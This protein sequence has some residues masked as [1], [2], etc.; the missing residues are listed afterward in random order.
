MELPQIKGVGKILA[1]LLL[2][3][4]TAFAVQTI[5]AYF[6]NKMPQPGKG[7]DA[8]YSGKR[9]KM[10]LIEGKDSTAAVVQ[11]K[12][13]AGIVELNKKKDTLAETIKTKKG[14]N[15]VDV[16]Y[17]SDS[18]QLKTLTDSVSALQ[19]KL[20]ELPNQHNDISEG[21]NKI[22]L[23]IIL[24]ILVATMGFLGNMVHIASSFTSFIGNGTFEKRW[25]LWY[26]VKPFTAAGLA[27]IIY[28]VIRAGFMGYGS[29][30]SSVNLYGIL[31][32]SA[33]AGLFTDNATLKLK[34]V[35]DV[36]FKPKDERGDKLSDKIKVTQLKPD[37]INRAAANA[38]IIAGEN[39]DKRK[40]TVK[41]NG[42]AIEAPVIKP[43]SIEFTY[44]VAE[45]DRTKTSFE[46]SIHD[47]SGNEVYTTKIGV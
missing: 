34:E 18:I 40:L 22:H 42:T 45:P 38:F 3:L 47:D 19:K 39:F 44:T 15:P 46:L 7:E 4:A 41:V 35:F 2:I 33:L 25:I 28:F 20:N 5:L 8:W 9:F 36:I 14:K 32:L 23:N 13:T 43:K 6:P 30:A 17:N 16:T 12:L 10:T 27:V 31:A 11:K 21:E 26:F 37:K 24:L 1:G 29:D